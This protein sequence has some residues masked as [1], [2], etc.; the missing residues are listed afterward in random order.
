MQVTSQKIIQWISEG[1]GQG[2]GKEYIP[3]L[4]IKR[5]QSPTGGSLQYRYIPQFDRYAHLMSKQELDVVRFLL[6]VG[7]VDV[8]EQFPCWPWPHPHPL[9]Q[10]SEYCPTTIPWSNGTLACARDLGIKH[11]NFP[12]TNIPYIPT[13]D[14]LVTLPIAGSLR[15]VAIAVKPD[16]DEV[17]LPPPNRVRR[18]RCSACTLPRH[19]RSSH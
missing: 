9:Y 7:V 5:R 8:R 11:P 2:H 18:R 16:E 4:L 19:D 10:H 13:L 14:M 1:R 6:W 12:G 17:R 15:A 3:W